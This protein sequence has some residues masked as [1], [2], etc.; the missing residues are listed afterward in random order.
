[1]TA[2]VAGSPFALAAG[3]LPAFVTSSLWITRPVKRSITLIALVAGLLSGSV[4]LRR[5]RELL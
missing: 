5:Y 2:F 1:M 3:S 4:Q